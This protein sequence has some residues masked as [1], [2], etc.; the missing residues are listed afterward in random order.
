MPFRPKNK[1]KKE[2]EESGDIFTPTSPVA[3]AATERFLDNILGLPEMM[4]R[5]GNRAQTGINEQLAG[6]LG[7]EA[8]NFL[9]NPVAESEQE[10]PFSLPSGRQSMAGIDAVLKAMGGNFDIAGSFQEGMDVRSALE[11][12]NPGKFQFG[13]H[14]GDAA[15]ILALRAPAVRASGTGDILAPRIISQLEKVFKP[16]LAGKLGRVFGRSTEAGLEAT[17]LALRDDADPIE[18]AAFAAGTQAT[19]QGVLKLAEV[20]GAADI[21]QGRLLK[22]GGKIMAAAFAFGGLLQFLESGTPWDETWVQSVEGGFDKILPMMVL[23]GTA[24]MTGAGRLSGN[25]PLFKGKM[26][27][28]VADA[29]TTLPRGTMLSLFNDLRSDSNTKSLVETMTRDPSS[30][31][32][33]Q[34]EQAVEAF[35]AGNLKEVAPDILKEAGI[36]PAGRFKRVDDG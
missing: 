16:E 11:E 12:N 25:V 15:S 36:A 19:A 3:T 2:D 13:S 35:E 31:T 10:L 8:A 5:V 28:E 17:L 21:A 32:P 20:A 23:G 30:L 7:P 24:A 33:E 18:A 26:A 14:L 34:I 6:I 9:V 27:A 1:P 29:F 4:N 22:G